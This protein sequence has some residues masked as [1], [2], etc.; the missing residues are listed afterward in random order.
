MRQFIFGPAVVSD[1]ARIGPRLQ[2]ERD[3][4]DLRSC[5]SAGSGDPRTRCASVQ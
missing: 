2:K 1:P 5:V 3:G 4:G